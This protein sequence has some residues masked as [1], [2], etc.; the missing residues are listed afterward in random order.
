MIIVKVHIERAGCNQP[1][2]SVGRGTALRQRVLRLTKTEK[3]TA[4]KTGWLGALMET[5]EGRAIV[6]IIS[7]GENVMLLFRPLC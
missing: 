5:R 1:I 7:I 3:F 4:D 6:T 2:H